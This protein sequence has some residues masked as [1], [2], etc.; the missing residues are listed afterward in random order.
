[1]PSSQILDMDITYLPGVGTQR[2]QLLKKELGI[3]TLRDLLYHFPYK[4]IDRTRFYKISELDTE[5]P[6]VQI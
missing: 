1:M 2:A 6:L 5:M 4:Y 3:E